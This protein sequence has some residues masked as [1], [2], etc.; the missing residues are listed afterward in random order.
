MPDMLL[1]MLTKEVLG[2]CQVGKRLQVVLHERQN[3]A[4]P[5]CPCI[6]HVDSRHPS[7][8][9]VHLLLMPEP[10]HHWGA[11]LPVK[12]LTITTPK[13]KAAALQRLS[14]GLRPHLSNHSSCHYPDQT[15]P[16]CCR[17]IECCNS[18]GQVPSATD[19]PTGSTTAA[20]TGV[21]DPEAELKKSQQQW[22][23]QGCPSGPSIA[24]P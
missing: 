21:P 7:G 14:A 2:P 6:P 11:M 4:S 15:S 18:G 13:H 3:S 20:A 10:L 17:T 24:P 12:H 1:I 23:V 5:C 9:I 19:S 16:H 22:V 8:D